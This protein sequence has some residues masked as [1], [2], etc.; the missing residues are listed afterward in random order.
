MLTKY[1]FFLLY[2]TFLFFIVQ[3]TALGAG[4]LITGINTITPP[5]M[6]AVDSTPVTG[7]FVTFFN[8]IG[9]AI[10]NLAYFLSLMQISSTFAMFGALILAPFIIVTGWIIIELMV[11]IIGAVVSMI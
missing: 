8:F 11:A 3:M 1:Q 7:L 2:G 5:T 6:P 9:W 10:T 4:Q